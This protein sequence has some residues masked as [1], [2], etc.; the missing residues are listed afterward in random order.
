MQTDH[1]CHEHT[2]RKPFS[3]F[4]DGKLS[5][6]GKITAIKLSGIQVTTMNYEDV[7]E[8]PQGLLPAKPRAELLEVLLSPI[9]DDNIAKSISRV[10]EP[11]LTLL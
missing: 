3:L 5:C 10:K 6:S 11:L 7:N 9:I 1:V 8:P 4:L 2:S